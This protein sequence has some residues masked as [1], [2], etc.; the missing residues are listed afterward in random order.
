MLE[1]FV[2]EF[3]TSPHTMLIETSHDAS[4]PLTDV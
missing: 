1:Y 3:I 4:H 2:V